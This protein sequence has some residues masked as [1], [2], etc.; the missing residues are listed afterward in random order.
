MTGRSWRLSWLVA[1]PVA[2]MLWIVA[3]AGGGR[4]DWVAVSRGSLRI[5]VE[6]TGT[7]RSQDSA[8]VSPP[9]VN[10]VWE[11]KIAWLGPEGSVVQIGQPVVRFD[12]AE[13]ERKLE[14]KV[15][16]RDQAASEIAKRR[17]DEAT[18]RAD[19]ELALAEAR[20]ALRKGDLKLAV[21]GDLIASSELQVARLEASL[22][23]DHVAHLEREEAAATRAAQAEL[24]ML[25]ETQRRAAARVGEIQRAIA[26]MQVTAPRE[27]TFILATNWRDEKKK[28]GDS[29]WRGE[30]IAEIADLTRM[31]AVGEVEEADA[32]RLAAGQA[33]S[34]VLDAHP[35]AKFAGRVAA[36]GS[37]VQQ[38]TWRDPLKVVKLEIELERT[39]PERMRPGMRFR[40]Q[41]E[42][43]RI[44]DVVTLP[45]DL[46]TVT[47]A[48]PMV[49]R[50]T[51]TGSEPVPV[52]L[53]RRG[54]EAVEVIDG[55]EVGDRV[56]RL[57]AT[58]G[59]GR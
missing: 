27:G 6:L 29:C 52:V 18:R 40:G 38:R 9:Q 1:V 47:D 55:L 8:S 19:S 58:P 11:Y 31:M 49:R 20:A 5:A 14:Q 7:L 39:D 10:G 21:P 57:A 25:E 51:L 44:D 26:D 37:T 13:L 54:L 34:L 16:E 45:T 24:A 22:A 48:G 46:V 42:I 59:G 56:K 41:V 30:L 33:V 35:N 12:T 3:S 36:V 4:D 53:G 2:A 43:E 28:A 17:A 50:R 32:G 15:A 23:A